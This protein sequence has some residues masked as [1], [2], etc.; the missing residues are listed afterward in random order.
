M[1]AFREHLGRY[2]IFRIA[3]LPV[4]LA[5]RLMSSVIYIALHPLDPF[6]WAAGAV[7][8]CYNSSKKAKE[9]TPQLASA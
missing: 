7:V 4:N 8:D 5:L 2:D 1:P 6:I 3:L 9:P